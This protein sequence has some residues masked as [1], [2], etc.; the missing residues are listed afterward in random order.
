MAAKKDTSAMD[1][2]L[3]TLKKNK[4]ASYAE[5]KAAA[6]EKGLA[7][8]PIMYGRAQALLGYVPMKPRGQGKAAVAKAAKAAP[9]PVAP[10]AGAPV[11][12]GPGRPP[13]SSYVTA[14]PSMD[15]SSLDGIINAVRSSE[16]AKARY[17]TALEKIQAIL[18]D[19]LA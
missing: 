11:K 3:A 10:I 17:R 2:I 16:S 15:L 5:V 19:A 1:F 6:D 18:G 8:Y 7:V 4:K 9:A 12:R 13:K 14:A